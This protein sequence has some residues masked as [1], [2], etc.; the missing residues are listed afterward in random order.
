MEKVFSVDE[1]ILQLEPWMQ[2]KF[3]EA[4]HLILTFPEIKECIRYNAPFYD[5]KGMML[6]MGIY[7][8][9]RLVLGFCNGK[10]HPDTHQILIADA[11]Q[12]QIKHWEFSKTGK[13]N[14]RLLTSYIKTAM[15][16]QD[17]LYNLKNDTAGKKSRNK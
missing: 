15:Q 5:Y 17:Q 10:H 6:Y 7:R 14:L 11:G 3:T 9:K 4:R 12:T 8:K 2:D 16:V 13:T 1:Y